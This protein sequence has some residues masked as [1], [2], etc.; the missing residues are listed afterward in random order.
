M[1]RPIASALAG[2]FL[3]T[4]PLA[5]PSVSRAAEAQPVDRFVGAV[6][7]TF[8]DPDALL[9]AFKSRLAADDQKGVLELLGLDPVAAV[10]SDGFAERFAEIRDQAAELVTV[11]EL[12]PDRRVL[13][14]G[15]AVW[16]LPFPMV[17]ADGRWAFDTY[18]GLDEVVN[19]RIGENELHAIATART[20]VTAQEIYKETDWDGDG[21]LEYAQKLISTP[22]TYDGLYWP[23]GD[24]V[25][26]SPAG[27]YVEEGEI[28]GSG[29]G[30][31]YFGYRFRILPGQ[32]DN[33]A[34][35]KYDY[36]INGNMIAGFGLIASPV[37]YGQTGVTTF[38]IN[39]YG[40]VYEKDLGE[41]TAQ[42]AEAITSFDPDDTWSV[43]T[44]VTQ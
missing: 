6:P 41:D 20:Y 12:A 15:R 26:A 22:G 38:V 23:S 29:A 19:R 33:I 3:L 27:Q 4:L 35:G 42:V 18:E 11:Q 34:G 39:Q 10:A 40:T 2:L 1:L 28:D 30:N 5:M 14:L 36:L 43:V 16:P 44:D 24:G 17:E 25:P 9:A 8:D 21:V 32:G 31:G 13:L 7:E 37:E